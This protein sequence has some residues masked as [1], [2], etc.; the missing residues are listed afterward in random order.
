MHRRYKDQGVVV[1]SV[2][3]DD[4]TDEGTPATVKKFLEKHKATMTNFLL[5]EKD[6]VWK[7]KLNVLA[8]PCVYVFNKAGQYEE[9]FKEKPKPEVIDALV[10]RLLKQKGP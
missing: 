6:E 4:I 2:S 5:D 10:D 8:L 1:I 3:T 9:K 7:D